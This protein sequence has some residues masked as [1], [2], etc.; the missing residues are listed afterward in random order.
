MYT[1]DSSGC[2]VILVTGWPQRTTWPSA[3]ELGAISGHFNAGSC[4]ASNASNVRTRICMLSRS[5]RFRSDLFCCIVPPSWCSV[6][7]FVQRF[8][9]TAKGAIYS[10]L[11]HA[12]LL[13]P[14]VLGKPVRPARAAAGSVRGM[15]IAGAG[16]HGLRGRSGVQAV[17]VTTVRALHVV[18]PS[19]VPTGY[20]ATRTHSPTHANRSGERRRSPRRSARPSSP[21]DGASGSR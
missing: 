13:L 1:S 2:S 9:R 4:D 15:T 18:P 16:V 14:F 3:Q 11:L 19:C 8:Q 6:V 20:R 10:V 21:P 5:C 7:C 12:E 17:W